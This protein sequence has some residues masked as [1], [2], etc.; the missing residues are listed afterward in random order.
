VVVLTNQEQI[1][2][3]HVVLALMVPM[4]QVDLLV[5]LI[6]RPVLIVI[7]MVR[8]VQFVPLVRPITIVLAV[9]I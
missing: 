5:V 6:A 1:Q 3:L 8:V 7:L 2:L 4:L 9:P